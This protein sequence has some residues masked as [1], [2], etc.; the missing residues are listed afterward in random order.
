METPPQE[1]AW[2][3]LF[4]LH[5]L[6]RTTADV[7]TT[8][9]TSFDASQAKPPKAPVEVAMSAIA[10]HN[11]RAWKL[12]RDHD[13]EGALAELEAAMILEPDNRMLM[14]NIKRIQQRLRRPT[15]PEGD[16]WATS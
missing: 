1:T 5:E 9:Q 6:S 11:D 3:H 16:P 2:A 13:Y 8:R 10:A 14:A 4:E 7:S 15:E 12:F